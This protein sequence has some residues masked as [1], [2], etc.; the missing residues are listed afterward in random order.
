MDRLLELVTVD[1]VLVRECGERL[2]TA[3]REDEILSRDA[4]LAGHVVDRCERDQL[5]RLRQARPRRIAVARLAWIGDG[6][7]LE[8]SAAER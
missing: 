6:S 8:A 3:K 7:R 4:E 5:D 1:P 2:L